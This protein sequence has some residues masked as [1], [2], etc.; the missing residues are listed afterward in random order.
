MSL[1]PGMKNESHFA[2][3]KRGQPFVRENGLHLQDRLK[4]PDGCAEIPYLYMDMIELH[5]SL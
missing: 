5:N 1:L 3:W 2:K 4:P